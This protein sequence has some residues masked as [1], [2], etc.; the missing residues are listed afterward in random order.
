MLLIL[1]G[2]PDSPGWQMLKTEP[3]TSG[4]PE[5]GTEREPLP[6]MGL[7]V[8]T[9]LASLLSD[10]PSCHPRRLRGNTFSLEEVEALGSS[11]SR[12]LL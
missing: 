2:G 9:F 8:A 11:D 3:L 10:L 6:G 1:W 5:A 4:K 7:R 12:L